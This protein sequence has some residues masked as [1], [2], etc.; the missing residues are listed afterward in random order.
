MRRNNGELH[1]ADPADDQYKLHRLDTGENSIPSSRT[2]L[3]TPTSSPEIETLICSVAPK[4]DDPNWFD[5]P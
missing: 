2:S 3:A 1:R 5:F 4:P